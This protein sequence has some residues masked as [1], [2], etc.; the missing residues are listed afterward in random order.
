ME[1]EAL[2]RS[3]GLSSEEEGDSN[4]SDSDD[5]AGSGRSSEECPTTPNRGKGMTTAESPQQRNGGSKGKR[6][7]SKQPDPSL[8]VP[9]AT[10]MAASMVSTPWNKKSTSPV[11]D[12]IS[13][14]G[15]GKYPPLP[16]RVVDME[17]DP[18][19]LC[20][21]AK[22]RSE[23]AASSQASA[24]LPTASPAITSETPPANPYERP[25]RRIVVNES[26]NTTYTPEQ[27]AWDGWD[28]DLDKGS[29]EDQE[30][31]YRKGLQ[32]NL[33]VKRYLINYPYLSD[34]GQTIFCL[35]FPSRDRATAPGRCE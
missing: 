30:G 29:D 1:Y 21:A 23:H 16:T 17:I 28:S 10:G 27:K 32:E 18:V 7:A 31:T 11:E 19:T 2:Y 35:S 34:Y 15:T 13:T 22:T 3:V 5:E 6:V 4:E 20:P 12:Q 33:N 25:G 14:F 24:C 8:S 26:A 9:C